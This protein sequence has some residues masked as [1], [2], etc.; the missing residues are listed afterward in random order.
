[1]V[2]Q[3]KLIGGIQLFSGFL[4]KNLFLDKLMTGNMLFPVLLLLPLFVFT[5][6]GISGTSVGIYKDIFIGNQ[7]DPNLISGEPRNIRSDEWIFNTQAI[8][9]QAHNHYPRF[10]EDIGTGVDM[11]LIYDVPYKDWSVIFKPLN[12]VFFVLPLENAFALK[13]W[14]MGY[15]LII[16]VYF[17][18]LHFRPKKRLFAAALSMLLFFSPMI[19]WW[20]QNVNLTTFAFATIIL[21]LLLKLKSSTKLAHQVAI[22]VA[23][24]YS[25][26]SFALIQY[27][28]FQIPV[29]IT[30]G[31]VFLAIIIKDPLNYRKLF[32]YL[33]LRVLTVSIFVSILIIGLFVATRQESFNTI[34]DTSYPGH[35]F[36][37][38]GGFPFAHPFNNQLAPLL[39][40][41]ERTKNY[42][43]EVGLANQSEASNFIIP[44]IPVLLISIYASYRYKRLGNR[45]WIPLALL[46]CTVL[47]FLARLYIPPNIVLDAVSRLLGLTLV[48]HMRLLF[49]LGFATMILYIMSSEALSKESISKHINKVV[50]SKAVAIYSLFTLATF[51]YTQ[52]RLPGVVSNNILVSIGIIV[53]M[54]VFL[55]FFMSKKTTLATITLLLFAFFS[56][57]NANPL[58]KGLGYLDNSPLNDYIQSTSGSGKRWIATLGDWRL[59]NFGWVNGAGSLS[60][61]YAYPQNDIWRTLDID[62]EKFAKY[63]SF[64]HATFTLSSGESNHTE[65]VPIGIGHFNIRTSPCSDFLKQYNV[66]YILSNYPLDSPCIKSEKRW[67]AST[68]LYTYTL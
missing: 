47:L 10:N 61:V 37:I 42:Y 46:I 45:L 68:E 36:V 16:S 58:Y 4:K 52:V 13:W 29:A 62:G 30:V 50:I 64:A 33:W 53:I 9:S 24:T 54:P 32:N 5:C 51:L 25:L 20:Y 6:A 44:I 19:Q 66:G 7:N 12:L 35:R 3:K 65:L 1:M 18:C 11:S 55:Y 49:G 23:L 56:T 60:G 34:T 27:P 28:P 43:P 59:E 21:L 31:V 57:Y 40:S 63:N 67:D 15:L 8:I 38:T 41:E 48:P 39:G 26:V 2:L 14:L 22:G 17:L